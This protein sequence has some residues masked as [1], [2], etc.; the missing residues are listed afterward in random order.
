VSC[1]C[2]GRY[3]GLT[4]GG[5]LHCSVRTLCSC[6]SIVG[7]G[8]GKS[9]PPHDCANLFVVPAIIIPISIVPAAPPNLGPITAPNLG[10]ASLP[11]LHPL[12]PK[13]GIA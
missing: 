3:D 7:C 13:I 10:P 4:S 6:G 8:C 12:P 1:F 2:C 11:N 9:F 5:C